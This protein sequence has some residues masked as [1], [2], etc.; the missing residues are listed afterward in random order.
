[1]I[2]RPVFAALAV[3]AALGVALPAQDA[4]PSVRITSPA[5]GAPLTGPVRLVAVVDPPAATRLVKEVTFFAGGHKVCT[6]SQQP[7]QCEWDAGDRVI[8]HSIRV[9]ARL[10]NGGSLVATVETQGYGYVEAVDVDVIQLTAVVTDGGDRFVKGLTQTDFKV[11]DDNKQQPITAF[12]SDNIELDLVVALDV[13][14]SMKE[15]LPR[16]KEA[17]KRFLEGLRLEDQVT[18]IV[19]NDTVFTAADRSKD[20]AYRV[21]A[22]NR[23]EAWG[24]TSLYDALIDSFNR[25]GRRPGRRAVVLFSDGDDQT[26]HAGPEE[27]IKRAEAT[28]AT[29]YVIG[30]GRAVSA[31]E[32]QTKLERFAKTSGGRPFFTDDVARLDR[33]FD[34]ILEDLRNQYLVSYAYPHKERDGQLHQIRLEVGGGRYKVRTRQSYRLTPN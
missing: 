11:F 4:K 25:L 1:M 23:L 21:G 31:R 6:V 34:E 15:A 14:S 12:R 3:A 20:H 10:V 22:I 18:L 27:A 33:F 29:I 24:G 30:Q 17:A 5:E 32:L 13:S 9:V 26:S 28:D 16:V 7:F 19:F 2:L 8:K